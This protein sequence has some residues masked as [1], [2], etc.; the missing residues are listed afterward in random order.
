MIAAGKAA[1]LTKQLLAYSGGG[2]YVVRRVDLCGVILE[3]AKLLEASISKK[4]RLHFDL[5]TGTATIEADPDQL[6]QLLLNLVINAAE[7]I[8]EAAGKIT[9]RTGSRYWPH[10]S[11]ELAAGQ[12]VVLEVEDTGIGMEESVRSRVFEPFFSTKFLGRGMGLAAVM[13]IARAHKGTVSV[14]SEPGRGSIF[15]VF[16]PVAVSAPATTAAGEDL[17]GTG[18]VLVVDD[19]EVV[20]QTAKMALQRYGY[21]VLLAEDGRGAIDLVRERAG[22][23]RLVLL[24]MTMPVMGGDEAFLHLAEIAPHIPVI[25]STG[26]SEAEAAQRFANRQVGGFIQ[27]PYTAV[28]LARLVKTVL[29]RSGLSH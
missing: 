7:A 18:T 17:T 12:Y 21:K 24:D 20:R 22:Q 4:I 5:A 10:D 23:I 11:D 8:G 13:G 1:D 26:Y 14:T 27:K 29:K 28:Q 15:S 25:A 3:T 9:I 16:F 19:E 2:R 6:R